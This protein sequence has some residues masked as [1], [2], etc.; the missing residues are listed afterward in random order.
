MRKRNRHLATLICGFFVAIPSLIGCGNQ[1][2]LP[3]SIEVTSEN[4]VTTI[5]VSETLQLSASILPL[6]ATDKTV[7]WSSANDDLATI[8]ETG[9]VTA[10]AVTENG[11]ILTATSNADTTIKGEFTLNVDPLTPSALTVASPDD[12]T[13]LAIDET[14][15]L[16]VSPSPTIASASVT[17]SSS[18]S[19]IISISE[20]GLVTAL[21]YT[22]EGVT[23]TAASVINS[24]ITGSIVLY[25]HPAITEISAVRNLEVSQEIV[26][27]GIVSGF[28][29]TGQS[30]P[31]ITGMYIADDTGCIY[32][33]GE[34]QAKSVS[35]YNEVIVKGTKSYY[36]PETDTGS[37][38]TM[39]YQGEL[40]LTNPVI[41]KNNGGTNAIPSSAITVTNTLA[42]INDVPITT[43]IT[44]NLYQITGRILKVEGSGYTNYYLQDLNRVDSLL[45]YTQ[46]N[47]KD[48]SYLDDYDGKA[49][50]ILLN[51][52]LAK[53]GVNAWRIYPTTVVEEITVTDAQEVAYGLERAKLDISDE[54]AE[55]VSI[56]FNKND[57]ALAGLTRT[58]SSTNPYIAITE[59]ENDYTIAIT[60]DVT[61]QADLLITVSYNG[62]VNS[63]TKT[64]NL[65]GKPEYT[66]I[67]L[68]EARSQEDGT[69]VTIEAV[70]ARLVYKSG[71]DTPLGAFIADDT[72]SF[73]I[74]NNADYMESLSEVTEGNL[75]A[76][77]G[78]VTHYIAD[79]AKATANNYSGDFQIKDITLIYNDNGT[80]TIPSGIIASTT[81]QA[82]TETLGSTNLSGTI[83]EVSGIITKTS[84]S[85]Y[86]TY[87][88]KDA[89]QTYSLNVYSQKNGAEFGWLDEYV[90]TQVTMY[91]G[92][93]NAK[94]SS[95][96]MSW[97]VC[98]VSIL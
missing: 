57:S 78:T 50:S 66:A 23:I 47:G 33:Y 82:I 54:F 19:E 38:A 88:V 37:A 67:S 14:L 22:Y 58:I 21:D 40:Q 72:D 77:S 81:V 86:S 4:N 34:N 90:G 83:F 94:L 95:T 25:V 24:E 75:I 49:V 97:R 11:V 9:L 36:I 5:E 80:H 85:F 17:W 13:T 31:Y 53:P 73:F 18:D 28:V 16:S 29:Y 27:T 70:V 68:H 39:N 48:F 12:Q 44:G 51:V 7:T 46:C 98:P 91:L 61:G 30:T 3:T 74:Y 84:S 96:T 65:V 59:N 76:V 62:V 69:M 8:S 26:V 2:I 60:V 56:T 35:L 32:I 55:S 52:I 64:I 15:Q 45:V 1:K 41:L 43:D 20:T 10:V 6:E 42:T 63:T 71:T 92:V 93:Q 79:A 87:Y 89:T